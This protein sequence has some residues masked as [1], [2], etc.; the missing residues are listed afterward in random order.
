MDFLSMYSVFND[1]LQVVRVVRPFLKKKLKPEELFECYEDLGLLHRNNPLVLKELQFN[2]ELCYNNF[3]DLVEDFTEE[4]SI[5]FNHLV[6][7]HYSFNELVEFFKEHWF[8][9]GET[10]GYVVAKSF[11]DDDLFS[12]KR[13]MENYNDFVNDFLEYVYVPT[14]V[15]DL[16]IKGGDFKVFCFLFKNFIRNKFYSRTRKE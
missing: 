3:D 10:V 13:S 15:S 16:Y 1:W 9:Y 7:M 14:Q 4:L 5:G 11:V 12:T 8:D 2:F 6:P